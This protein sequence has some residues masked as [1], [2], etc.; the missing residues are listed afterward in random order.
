MQLGTVSYRGVPCL[1]GESASTLPDDSRPAALSAPWA[2]GSSAGIL[3]YAVWFALLTGLIES[4]FIVVTDLQVA[5]PRVSPDSVWMAPLAD[6]FWI[7]LPGL[8]VGMVSI[9]VTPSRRRSLSTFVIATMSWLAIVSLPDRLFWYALLVLGVGLG[10]QTTRVILA[11]SDPFDRLIH[12]TL[13]VLMALTGLLIVGANAMAWWSESRAVAA[14]APIADGAPNVVLLVI[15]TGRGDHASVHGYVRATTPYLEEL[16]AGGVTFANAVSSSSWTLPGHG[17]MF[18]GH[19]P[20]HL[21]AG[22]A[23]PLD[24]KYPTL[25]EALESHGYL[26]AGFVANVDFG[27]P[28]Y[29]LGRGFNHY[30]VFRKSAAEFLM[31]SSLGRLSVRKRVVAKVTGSTDIAGRKTGAQVTDEFLSWV[32]GTDRPFFAFLNYFDTHQPFLP[33]DS[34]AVRFGAQDHITPR[35]LVHTT[36]T[37]WLPERANLEPHEIEAE[38]DAYDAA[39][40]YVDAEIRRAVEGLDALGLL[41]GTLLIV[42]G[43]H[44][45]SLGEHGLFDHGSTLY[46]PQIHVPLVVWF[47]GTIPTG[48]QVDD[49]VSTTDLAATVLE[50]TEVPNTLGLA[51]RSLARWWDTSGAAA[52][53]TEVVAE[54]TRTDGI[55]LQAAIVGRM[56]YIRTGEGGDW[57]REELYDLQ[58]D[59]GEHSNLMDSDIERG[60]LRRARAVL[61]SITLDM[62]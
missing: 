11:R 25:A 7:G 29:G 2:L 6:L 15:D 46:Q 60:A 50:L 26:T 41:E 4:A 12:R 58:T 16:S 48:V 14:L 47:P 37:A 21:S 43:D 31:S 8:L 27:A 39:Y 33:P 32:E 13:P 49:F 30:R 42:T 22:W 44:G 9:R 55:E 17:S 40:A 36:R 51:G 52:A 45:E 18:T 35:E 19:P 34:F 38:I 53:Q 10:V 5:E 28:A 59:R 1:I 56:K 3:A 23:T 57:T 62:P 20:G 54:L 24:G 61:D